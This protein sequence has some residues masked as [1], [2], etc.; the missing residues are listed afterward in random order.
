MQRRTRGMG[1]VAVVLVLVVLAAIAAAVVRMGNQSHSQTIQ[2]LQGARASA[3]ART[4][5]EWGLYKAFRGSWTN[6]SNTSQT[7]DLSADGGGMRVTVR[8]NS[9]QFNE[10]ETVPGTAATARVYTI[11]A[12][13]CPSRTAL[14]ACPDASTATTQSYVERRRVIQ[15]VQPGS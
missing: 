14:T 5:I 4:G 15:A 3:A 1:A 13:A 2:A 8:C 9:Q 6:C 10:G 12:V 11:D 7:L